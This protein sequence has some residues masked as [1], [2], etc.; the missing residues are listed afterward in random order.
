MS[1][2]DDRRYMAL[3]LALGRRGQGQT[4][5]NPAVGCVIVR[6]GRIVGR[7]RTAPG[8]RPHAEPQALA[9]AGAAAAG[10]TAYV[11]LEP[12]SHY[13]QTP[14]CV[15]ALTGAGIARVVI[16]HGDPDPRVAGEGVEKLR[17]AGVEVTE[18]VCAEA[19]ASDH[20]GFF[21]RVM[22]NRPWVTL[23]LA[24]SLDGRIAMAT[25]ESQWI[26]GPEARRAVH[27]MRARHDA[28]M[29]GAGTARADDPSLTVRGLGIDRQP[30]RVVLSRKLD[31]PLDGQLARTAGEVPVWI[32]HAPDAAAKAVA[33][34]ED[35]GARCFSA[36]ASGRQIDP[37]AA[38]RALAGAG[39]TRV[40]CE[41]G[42]SLA[43]S[44][45]GAGLVDELVVFSAG[46]VI[47]AEGL[48]AI[49]AMGLDRL[50]EAPRFDLW[51]SRRVGADQ[52]Q[53]WRR[54]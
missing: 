46:T 6:D 48:P 31:L 27:G 52:L 13:G 24:T 42:G 11:S 53:I 20:A 30:V 47:G 28:V 38:L 32:V 19:A 25:G 8:G 1:A 50:A 37:A 26:T 45:L 44:L 14:P 51:E 10:A 34:W 16:A 49:A 23:K 7:G 2:A 18:D 33:A 54:A 41:G 36:P 17:A 39:L 21:L 12:C 15:D 4:W 22:E 3:A 40:F 35:L 43:A 9:Q 5:P 29:V